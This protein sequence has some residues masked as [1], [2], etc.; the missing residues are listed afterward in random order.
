MTFWFR[1]AA[2]GYVGHWAAKVSGA[3]W[4]QVGVEAEFVVDDFGELV[5]RKERK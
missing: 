1:R 3:G 4:K 5:L 2:S